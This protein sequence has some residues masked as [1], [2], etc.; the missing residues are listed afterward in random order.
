MAR[1]AAAVDIR[2][3]PIGL[4]D[5]RDQLSRDQVFPCAG[6]WRIQIETAEITVAAARD[7]HDHFAAGAAFDRLVHRLGKSH[8]GIEEARERLDVTGIAVQEIHGR[9]APLLAG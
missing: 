5:P 1:Y 3:R 9:V 4:V 6:H 2:D 8:L 7:Y